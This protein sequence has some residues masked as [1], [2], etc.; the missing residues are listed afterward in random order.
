MRVPRS[1]MDR[2]VIDDDDALTADVVAHLQ[3][4]LPEVPRAYP[5]GYFVGLVRHSALL[6][7]DHFGLIEVAAVRLFVRL[8]WEIGA[9]FYRHPVIGP[10]LADR[11]LP[12]MA[13]FEAL[14]TP[15]MEQRGIWL[16]A[17][18]KD[19]PEYWRGEKSD[20]FGDQLFLGEGRG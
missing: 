2:P 12:P 9:G 19:G 7:R 10:I 20:G 17:A 6:A 3:E 16:E 18:E 5:P 11:S 1:F 15:E 14:T 13:R 8:R 4:C